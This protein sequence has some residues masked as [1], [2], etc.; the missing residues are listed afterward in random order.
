MGTVYGAVIGSV[1]FVLAQ[2]YLQDLMKIGAGAIGDVPVLSQLVSPDRWLLWLGVL[3]VLSVYYFPTGVVGRLRAL[4]TAR[5]S[6]A[7][8]AARGHA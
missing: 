1:L 7:P 8:R 5:P 4:R 3:F 6:A 2:S